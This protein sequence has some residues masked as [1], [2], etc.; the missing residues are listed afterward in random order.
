M[1]NY[2]EKKKTLLNYLTKKIG[3]KK[4]QKLTVSQNLLKSGIIDSLDLADIHS[5]IEKI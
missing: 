3:K 2:T 5:F 4:I 1:P